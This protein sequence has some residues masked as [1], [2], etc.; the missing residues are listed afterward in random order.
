[1]QQDSQMRD[2][3]FYSITCFIRAHAHVPFRAWS[4]FI[5]F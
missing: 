5:G 1:M 3:P 4:R 2:L